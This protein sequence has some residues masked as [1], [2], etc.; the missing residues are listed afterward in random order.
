MKTKPSVLTF[1]L[2]LVAGLFALLGQE[3]SAQ[4]TNMP[5]TTVLYTSL[6]TPFSSALTW[7]IA[8]TAALTLIGW[9][10]KAVRRR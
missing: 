7:V 3:A 1:C 5:D 2:L 6:A 10:L 9:I 8:A 4:I